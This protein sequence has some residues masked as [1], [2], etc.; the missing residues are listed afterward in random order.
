[1]NA[2]WRLLSFSWHCYILVFQFGV[3]NEKVWPCR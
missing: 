1:L 2:D 3:L